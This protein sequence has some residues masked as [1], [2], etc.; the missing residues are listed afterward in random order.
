MY[1]NHC[2]DTLIRVLGSFKSN[3]EILV[4]KKNNPLLITS[5]NICNLFEIVFMLYMW[6]QLC[7]LIKKQFLLWLFLEQTVMLS[8]MT[9]LKRWW[10]F[11]VLFKWKQSLFW[12]QSVVPSLWLLLNDS[13]SAECSSG[14]NSLS[15]W[16]FLKQNRSAPLMSPF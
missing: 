10:S 9:P 2:I 13:G 1:M 12:K 4:L 6:K 16:L 11:R 5:F 8:L 7:V 14:V 3:A 15:F